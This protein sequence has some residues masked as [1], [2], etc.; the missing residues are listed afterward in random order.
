MKEIW[1]IYLFSIN[2]IFYH[3]DPH[4]A[5]G[6]YTSRDFSLTFELAA[7]D[8]WKFQKDNRQKIFDICNL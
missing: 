3:S 4:L 8:K 5:S 6:L 2:D 1:L 7:L